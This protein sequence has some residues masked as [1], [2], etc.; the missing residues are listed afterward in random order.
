M[1]CVLKK[2]AFSVALM[3][4][5]SVAANA[6]DAGGGL[7]VDRYGQF[8]NVDF[9]A[10]VTSDDE[11][12]QDFRLDQIYYNSL[13]PPK[14]D[15]YGGLLNSKKK[16]GLNA[17]GFFHTQKLKN[18]RW[19]IVN[20]LGNA[21][22]SLGVCG[23]AYAGDTYTL[24]KGR[25]SIYEWLPEFTKDETHKDNKY[26]TA[27]LNG[28]RPAEFSFYAANRIKKFDQPFD[29]Y[30]FYEES[31][32][33]L[34]KWG[35]NSEGGWSHSNSNPALDFPQVRMAG[36]P[37]HL[38]IPG[39]TIYDIYRS[40]FKSSVNEG[41]KRQNIEARASSPLL[42]GYFFGNEIDYHQF[43]NIIP[44][45]KASEVATKK[46]LVDFLQKKYNNIAAYNKAWETNF[47]VFS[48]LSETA[49]ALT[50][51]K[52]VDDMHAFFEIYMEKFY[53]EV[54]EE[55]RKFDKNH[56]TLGDRYFT[57]VMQ[58]ETLRD[59]LCRVAAKHLDILSY[60]YYAYE[61][62]TERLKK[63]Y[64]LYGKPMMLTEFHYGDPTQGQ[65]SSIQMM[66]NEKE[67][68]EAYRSY[69]ENVAA[70][71]FVVGTHWFE[72]LDQS[73]TGRWFQ[74]FF[75]EGF[76]VG[77]LNVADRPYK[78]F[79]NEVMKTNYNIYDI[80]LGRKKPFQ[81]DFG[82]GKTGRNNSKEIT[83]FRTNQPI[84]IDGILDS[85]WPNGE[86]IT[87]TDADRV[88][89]T[90][91]E[92]TKATINLA[93]DDN[94][95]YLF[96]QV[97]ENSPATN[98]H[99]GR[100]IYNGDGVELFIGANNVQEGGT[101][102]V[103]DR[104]IILAASPD[105][106]PNYMWYNGVLQQPEIKTIT[107]KDADGNGYVLEAA[108]PFKDLNIPDIYKSRKIRFDIGLNDGDDRQRNTQYMWNG[109]ESNSR[110]RD[111][112]GILIFN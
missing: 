84:A 6:Q 12:K 101:L 55:F 9:A 65:T 23:V 14:R 112:W 102:Q 110:T 90:K 18:G 10:K 57:P 70:T 53:G 1:K 71:G 7:I 19:V 74:G 44:S 73:V 33:R 81:Y 8:K 82:P 93:Y 67:K 63:M 89:G 39:S 56:M 32:Y 96:A 79:L 72:Y 107:K 109:T 104:Q 20:P 36:L 80:M 105:G 16:L 15:K 64:Q 48:D 66:D 75:G 21:Y 111:D 98:A 51:E 2:I 30:K 69:V 94:Y 38:T 60:N 54:V 91:Q 108:I 92:S 87:L 40:D 29:N 52:A 11:L 78:V 95:L 37:G 46:A 77:L 13:K 62:D 47:N 83:I 4:V 22:F 50:T 24:I 25:E 17:T 45:K 97:K 106:L 43:K 58:D 49:I 31:V 34:R 3:F 88:T 27:F 35:F 85:H 86:A 28:E 59:I 99:K 42:I 100:N 103:R 61:V 5:I 41:F 68:G 76:G 26:R